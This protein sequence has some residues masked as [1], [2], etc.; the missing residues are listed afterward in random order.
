MKS[1]D[2]YLCTVKV[3]AKSG[4]H[5]AC[6]SSPSSSSHLV[7][8]EL[9]LGLLRHALCTILRGSSKHFCVFV[10]AGLALCVL[11]AAG[12]G[13]LAINTAGGVGSLSCCFSVGRVGLAAAHEVVD[14]GVGVLAGA[15]GGFLY[16]GFVSLSLVEGY[17]WWCRTPPWCKAPFSLL[18]A[19]SPDA[20]VVD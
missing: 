4:Y 5:Q 20:V 13:L 16:T 6:K 8:V 19:F 17:A 1:L 2:N 3:Y 14:E 18:A 12:Q 9:A 15:L 7:T 10:E 11:V